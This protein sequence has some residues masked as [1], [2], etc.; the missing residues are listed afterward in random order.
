MK[1]CIHHR[2]KIII[3]LDLLDTYNQSLEEVCPNIHVKQNSKSATPSD[4]F[5]VN[6]VEYQ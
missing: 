4:S 2:V 3:N 6:Q 1:T 5:L